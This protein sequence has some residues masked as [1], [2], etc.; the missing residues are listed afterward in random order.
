MKSQLRIAVV[1][2]L[3]LVTVSIT[4]T[5]GQDTLPRA[6]EKGDFTTFTHFYWKVVDTDPAGLNGREL[7]G[8]NDAYGELDLSTMPVIMHFPKGSLLLARAGCVDKNG[9]SWLDVMLGAGGKYCLVRANTKFVVPVKIPQGTRAFEI[10]SVEAS[11]DS[12]ELHSGMG[13]DTPCIE[14][15]K[16]LS[17]IIL[18][19]SEGEW[20]SVMTLSGQTGYM[21]SS[22]ISPDKWNHFVAGKITDPDGYTNLR[23][24][25]SKDEQVITKLPKDRMVLLAKP[26]EWADVVTCDAGEQ[27]GFIKSSLVEWF[28]IQ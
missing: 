4:T 8:E 9:A 3:V 15:V 23:K 16:P 13:A 2:T 5:S 10:R 24:G 28:I 7:K 27:R 18:L 19:S 6:N 20:W 25:P 11:K 14:K 22:R 21:K 17:R 12:A 26:G 1:I